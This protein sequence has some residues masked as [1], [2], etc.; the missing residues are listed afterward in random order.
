M[1]YSRMPGLPGVNKLRI[2]AVV[3][4]VIVIFVFTL[5]SVVTVQAGY[6]GV[7]LYLGQ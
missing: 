4:T 5:E 1:S 2:A 3:I 7:V 6:R